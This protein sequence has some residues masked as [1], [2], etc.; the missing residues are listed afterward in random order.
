MPGAAVDRAERHFAAARSV[1]LL[2]AT[3][4]AHA[5][6]G[7]RLHAE[8]LLNEASGRASGAAEAADVTAAWA[9]SAMQF[10]AWEQVL[11]REA[12]A[13][14]MPPARRADLLLL[15]AGAWARQGEIGRV[16]ERLAAAEEAATLYIRLDP[17][18]RELLHALRARKRPVCGRLRG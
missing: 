1:G 5:T 16:V 18:A 11:E 3:A 8:Q 13:A 12:G 14:S 10:G 6:A 17:M 15:A 7:H 9:G 4:F 2:C